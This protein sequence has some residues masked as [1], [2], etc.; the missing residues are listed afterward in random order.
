MALAKP[1][2]LLVIDGNNAKGY[3]IYCR[4]IEVQSIDRCNPISTEINFRITCAHNSTAKLKSMGAGG[5]MCMCI[6]LQHKKGINC[7]NAA[8]RWLMLKTWYLVAID[9]LRFWPHFL[10]FVSHLHHLYGCQLEQYAFRQC[11]ETNFS[12]IRTFETIKRMRFLF[13]NVD[14]TI[15]WYGAA[16]YVRGKGYMCLCFSLYVQILFQNNLISHP[17]RDR[18]LAFYSPNHIFT[19]RNNTNGRK[20]NSL[21]SM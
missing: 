19:V 6:S 20:V 14:S 15:N 1:F 5:Q 13:W 2:S 17:S 21:T 10:V 11:I 16:V 9:A 7:Q 3:L 8:H 18:L 4:S 12:I